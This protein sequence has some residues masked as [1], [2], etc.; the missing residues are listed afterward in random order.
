MPLQGQGQYKIM[1]KF[2]RKRWESDE[3]VVKR[4]GLNRQKTFG[5]LNHVHVVRSTG[6]IAKSPSARSIQFLATKLTASS[7][8]TRVISAIHSEERSRSWLPLPSSD[9]PRPGGL[10]RVCVPGRAVYWVSVSLSP[11][12][13]EHLRLRFLLLSQSTSR[14]FSRGSFNQSLWSSLRDLQ[15]FWISTRTQMAGG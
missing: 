14:L 15:S 6:I 13:F 2:S 3:L 9:K 10:K 8:H 5:V 4:T 12:S 7:A 1:F 11:A